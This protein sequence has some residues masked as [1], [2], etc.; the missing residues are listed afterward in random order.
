MKAIILEQHGNTEKLLYQ[1]VAKSE[2]E[3]GEVLIKIHSIGIN[4][5]DLLVRNGNVPNASVTFPHILGVEGAGTISEIG[6]GVT[7][8]HIGDRV[9]PV[10]TISQGNC[11]EPVCYCML[12]HDNICAKFDKL[13]HT[14]WGT[15]AEYVKSINLVFCPYQTKSHF[16]MLLPL[17]LLIQQRGKWQKK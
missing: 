6:A 15:Y 16:W 1:E 12:G 8:F 10:L 5:F 7:G 17:W 13:G 2:V 14:R 11:A 9:A 4:R 3:T